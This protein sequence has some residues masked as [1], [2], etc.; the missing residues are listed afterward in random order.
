MILVTGAT[1]TVGRQ[2]LR[3]LADPAGP[4]FAADRVRVLVRDP[5]RLDPAASRTAEVVT[6]DY[7]DEAALG[8]ALRGV[9]RALLVTTRVT[10]EDDVRFLGAAR[11]AGVRHVV[12]LSA[13]AVTDPG[14]DDLITTWQRDS[15]ALLRD[16]GMEWTLL[17]PRSFM[18][19]CLSW[20]PSIRSEQVVRALYG[21]S[22]NACVDPRD[23]AE[24]AVRALTEDGHDGR[25]YVLTGPRAISAADQTAELAR[26]LHVPLRLEELAADQARAAMGRRYPEPVVEAL[27]HS[28]H[29]QRAG[30]KTGVTDT[31]RRLTGRPA[32]S[33]ARWAEDHLDDFT[34]HAPRGD[35]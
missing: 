16:S 24:V 26:L 10:G 33:F 3:Q 2:V 13:A 11:A 22:L 35:R 1:G 31:V 21:S 12:K 9:D 8:R 29:R 17:R 20:A 15:E 4:G 6:A 27:L 30:A 14:A 23:V 34:V 5:A 25:A 7:G 18:S 28:A 19:N 32:R